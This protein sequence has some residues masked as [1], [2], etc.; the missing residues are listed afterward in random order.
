VIEQNVFRHFGRA[1]VID[2]QNG[3]DGRILG[4]NVFDQPRASML[5]VVRGGVPIDP[6]L[7]GTIVGSVAFALRSIAANAAVSATVRV[8]G[9]SVG[10]FVN[11]AFS[12]NSDGVLVSAAVSAPNTVSVRFENVAGSTITLPAGSIRVRVTPAP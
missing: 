10:D 5:P 11:A 6:G 1:I 3:E 12:E 2:S 9:A 7:D 8:S 4:R